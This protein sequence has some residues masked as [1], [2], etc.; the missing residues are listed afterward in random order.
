MS[1]EYCLKKFNFKSRIPKTLKCSHTYCNKCLQILIDNLEYCPI[2]RS[3]INNSVLINKENFESISFL[4]KIHQSPNVGLCCSHVQLICNICSSEHASCNTITLC[5]AKIYEY[6][7][8]IYEIGLYYSSYLVAILKE[9]KNNNLAPTFTIL[10]LKIKEIKDFIV[11]INRIG[12]LPTNITNKL[13]MIKKIKDIKPS[14]DT[15][16]L[17][18]IVKIN[19]NTDI[20]PTNNDLT[21]CILSLWNDPTFSD[22]MRNMLLP[23]TNHIY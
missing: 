18:E 11:E 13:S 14:K 9:N 10:D 1:C 21:N 4:C 7:K 19:F 17:N 3:K 23:Y 22:C 8:D 20:A 6:I 5:E 2:D 12:N 15:K 16:K